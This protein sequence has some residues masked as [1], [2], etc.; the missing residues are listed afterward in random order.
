MNNAEYW[1]ERAGPNPSSADRAYAVINAFDDYV[2][3]FPQR[4]VSNAVAQCGREVALMIFAYSPA[5]TSLHWK[6]NDL[7]LWVPRSGELVGKELMGVVTGYVDNRPN[8]VRVA[9]SDGA[10]RNCLC[11]ELQLPKL[12][13]AVF[14]L[15]KG[16]VRGEIAGRCPMKE[17]AP[18]L[19]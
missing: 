18:C 11:D 4:L 19:A 7:V 9:F 16:V 15:A 6:P 8:E 5:T 3:R 10:T 13:Q 1:S 2:K 17:G 12:P 14:D